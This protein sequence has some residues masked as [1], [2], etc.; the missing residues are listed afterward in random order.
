[1]EYPKT[2]PIYRREVSKRKATTQAIEMCF[3][4]PVMTTVQLEGSEGMNPRISRWQAEH[5]LGL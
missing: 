5:E 1:M 4:E 3:F 2:K